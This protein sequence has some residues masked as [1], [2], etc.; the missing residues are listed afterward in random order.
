MG[1][2]ATGRQLVGDLG[3][4]TRLSDAEYAV[5]AEFLPSAKSGGRPS[6][7]DRRQ[8][9]DGILFVLRTGCQWRHLPAAFPPWQTTYGFFRSWTQAG[10]WEE[11]LEALRCRVRL[12]EGRE[13]EP[14]VAIIDS[15]SVKTT[16]KGG[17]VATMRANG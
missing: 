9:L 2:T 1:W 12:S 14:S 10:V 11:A 6:H 13:A 4:G 5:F 16:E 8:V 3:F 17:F 7:T 15:Q